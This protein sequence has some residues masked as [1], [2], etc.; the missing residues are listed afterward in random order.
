MKAF[1]EISKKED[2]RFDYHELLTL[3]ACT[4]DEEEDERSLAQV[5]WCDGPS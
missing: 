1:N 3:A 4:L 5:G 2:G